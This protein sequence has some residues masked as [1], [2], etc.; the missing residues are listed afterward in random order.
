MFVVSNTVRR[1]VL[2]I[3]KLPSEKVVLTGCSIELPEAPKIEKE[4]TIDFL[5]L[6]RIGKFAYLDKIWEEIRTL[7][8]DVSFHMIGVGKDSSI[9]RRL[10]AIG[11]FVHHGVVDEKTKIELLL[12]SKVFIFP[13][14]FEGWGIAVGE[15]LSYGLPVIVWDLPFMMSFGEIAI[16]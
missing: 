7:R 14:A 5:C 10:E 1:D 4:K 2:K 6:G 8:N 9:V 3:F 12:N 11:N 16:V 15:A 13:S